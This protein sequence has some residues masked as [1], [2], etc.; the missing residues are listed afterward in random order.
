M[1]APA[2]LAAQVVRADAALHAHV[3]VA[4]ALSEQLV[5]LRLSD[6]SVLAK[7]VIRLLPAR[8]ARDVA[9]DVAAHRELARLTPARPLSSFRVGAAAAADRLRA[10]YAEA[11]RRSGV[12]WQLLAAVNFVESDFGRLR[13][14]SVSGALGPMQFIPSTWAAYGRGDV[15]D[16]HD[17][18][19]AAGRFLRAAGA[20]ADERRALYRYNA[21]PAYV[22]AV[23]RYAGRM[24]RDPA[25]FLVFYARRLIVRTPTGYRRLN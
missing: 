14:A 6:D 15:H 23:E 18:I 3:T 2:V 4:A 10:Y 11:Q 8:L 13:E 25:V 9:D 1:T 22:D 24:R 19:L 20:P 17:A 16:P 7:A 12:S 5:E 21:S